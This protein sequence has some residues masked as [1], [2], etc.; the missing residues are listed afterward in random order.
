[1]PVILHEKDEGIWLDPQLSDTERL[2]KLLKP[3]PFD[4][5]QTYKVSTLVNS[6]KNDTPECIE[7]KDD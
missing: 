1:M 2:S 7:P 6:P 5:M 4:H 3:Y